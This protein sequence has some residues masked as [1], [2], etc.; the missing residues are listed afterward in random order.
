MISDMKRLMGFDEIGDITQIRLSQVEKDFLYEAVGYPQIKNHLLRPKNKRIT[1][2]NSSIVKGN[3][4]GDSKSRWETV[5]FINHNHWR[6]KTRISQKEG[7]EITQA[8]CHAGNCGFDNQKIYPL[9]FSV[10]RSYCKLSPFYALHDQGISVNAFYNIRDSYMFLLQGIFNDD[11]TCTAKLTE[12]KA[13]K[14]QLRVVTKINPT[15]F[16]L[17]DNSGNIINPDSMPLQYTKLQCQ[18]GMSCFEYKQNDDYPCN[19]Y[20]PVNS[21]WTFSLSNHCPSHNKTIPST[22]YFQSLSV[23]KPIFMVVQSQS[24]IETNVKN[25][26]ILSFANQQS[27]GW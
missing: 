8:L 1:E 14:N 26:S 4:L 6:V 9:G 21:K 7:L 25:T 15:S 23:N 19:V 16:S 3:V 12:S 13:T 24:A 17:I 22:K 27:R 11:G 2:H 5:H 18:P 10:K 20:P